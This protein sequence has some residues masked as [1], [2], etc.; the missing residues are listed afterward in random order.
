MSEFINYEVNYRMVSI[1]CGES[2]VDMV[3]NKNIKLLNK[4]LTFA[5]HREYAQDMNN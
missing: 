1:H 5:L 2:V 3:H 4:L